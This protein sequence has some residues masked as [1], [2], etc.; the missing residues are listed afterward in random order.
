MAKSQSAKCDGQKP[1]EVRMVARLNALEAIVARRLTAKLHRQ[2]D[3]RAAIAELREML[4][5]GAQNEPEDPAHT[6]TSENMIEDL[7]DRVA[8]QLR[9]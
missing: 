7:L 6:D 9:V 2:N 3:K 4:E 5:A 1:I 8:R